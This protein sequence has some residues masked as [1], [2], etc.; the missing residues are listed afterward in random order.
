[1]TRKP[2]IS[3]VVP[4]ILTPF[5]DDLSIDKSAL[6][7]LV[8]RIASID[9]V[10]AIFCTGHAGEVAALSRSERKEVVKLTVE[11][12]GGRMPTLA[13][14]YTDS[15]TEAVDL[16]RDAKQAGASAMTLFPPPIFVDGGSDSYDMPFLWFQRIAETVETPVVVFQFDR[17][18][19]LGYTSDTLARLATLPEVIGVKEGSADMA[20]YERNLRILHAATPPVPVLTSNNTWLMPSLAAGGDGIIS[21]SS[22]VL[23]A[24][25]V[26]LWRAMDAGDLKKGRQINDQLYPMVQAFYRAPFINMHTRMKEALV[27]LGVLKSATVR[28]PLLPLSNEERSEIR[29]AL[30]TAKLLTPTP[31]EVG[32]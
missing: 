28:P 32:L 15:L 18:G 11:A 1:M 25:H 2:K 4:A 19:H 20:D 16:A 7:S 17:A 5:N 24:E 26:K 9:G 13:G 21:G 22:N 27:M 6:Q 31:A 30:Q 23:A 8:D 10:H 3:G 29:R 12:V 14:I